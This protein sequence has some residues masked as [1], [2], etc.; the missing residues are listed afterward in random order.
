MHCMDVNSSNIWYPETTVL[1]LLQEVP[2]V[3]DVMIDWNELVKKTSTGISSVREYHMVCRHLAYNDAFAER[4][5]DGAEP[6]GSVFYFTCV[7]LPFR[8]LDMGIC[9]RKFI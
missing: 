8:R 9:I 7:I 4:L 6:M 1:A 3:Q 2:Q 5:D